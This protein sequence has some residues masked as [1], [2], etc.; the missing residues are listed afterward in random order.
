MTPLSNI[1]HFGPGKLISEF[2]GGS[3]FFYL[4]TLSKDV[5]ESWD[6]TRETCSSCA[7][8]SISRLEELP[9]GDFKTKC[10]IRALVES[11]ENQD[12]DRLNWVV[13][14]LP[15]EYALYSDALL[16]GVL[17]TGVV[18]AISYVMPINDKG[19]ARA[20]FREA[21]VE[22][23]KRGQSGAVKYLYDHFENDK[24]LRQDIVVEACK[25]GDT[26]LIKWL[27]RATYNW[28]LVGIQEL[29]YRGHIVPLDYLKMTYS[30][31]GMFLSS[32]VVLYAA[33]GG[34]LGMVDWVFENSP[35]NPMSMMNDRELCL[36]V[37]RKGLLVMFK[38]LVYDRGMAFNR[39]DC[40]RFSKRGSGIREWLEHV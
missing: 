16:R 3:N 11:L 4:G 12:W 36:L 9:T 17:K 35:V 15:R 31:R 23:V 29:L 33:L 10:M 38:H 32:K 28:P 39:E 7:S 30:S 22:A 18:S 40:I 8:S 21:A 24:N 1:L 2:D 26:D 37:S 19:K 25:K 5:R 14:N 27:S 13:P 20:V 34:H 6:F